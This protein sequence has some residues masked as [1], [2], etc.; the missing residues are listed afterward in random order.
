MA[1]V[2]VLTTRCSSKAAVHH[3]RGLKSWPVAVLWVRLLGTA[4]P[5]AA[6][7]VRVVVAVL[8]VW[9]WVTAFASFATGSLYG[10]GL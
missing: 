5:S 4:T 7:F 10:D 6:G 9:V 2:Y 1:A 3:V 8:S